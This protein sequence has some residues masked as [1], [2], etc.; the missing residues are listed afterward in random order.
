MRLNA[1]STLQLDNVSVQS[2]STGDGA[3]GSI[4]V[5]SGGTV[6]LTGADTE[7]LTNSQGA[8]DAGDVSI[9]AD[10]TLRFSGGGFVQTSAVGSGNAGTILLSAPQVRLTQA[11]ID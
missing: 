7:L 5:S 8:S 1:G 11:R 9:I 3:S 4:L 10:D 6:E 2:A